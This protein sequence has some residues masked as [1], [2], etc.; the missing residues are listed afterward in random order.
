MKEISSKLAALREDYTAHSL[1]EAQVDGDPVKQFAA[2][3][4]EAVKAMVP[5]PNAMTLATI[6]TSGK[7]AARIV[8]L[9]GLSETGFEFFTNY[10]SAKATD[11]ENHAFVAVVFN[12]LP[13]Q[14]QVRI[15]GE[16]KKLSKESNDSY[17]AQRPYLSQ[18]GA[19]ASPQSK[20]VPDRKFL[21]DKF[22]ELRQKY[23]EGN[24][25]PRP[26]NWGGYVI[27]PSKI[28][29]WQGRRSRLHDRIVYEKG[30]NG[31]IKERL[32]P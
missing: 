9:K 16:I 23:P 2:W 29:F 26:D 6:Q 11:M 5:E 18:L 3:F 7:P 14:R 4:E 28:E 31:W 12:W 10:E 1:D 15:E 19:I 8:L 25:V 30:E 17:F 24:M 21:E 20:R 32:A 27:I 13:L 22:E